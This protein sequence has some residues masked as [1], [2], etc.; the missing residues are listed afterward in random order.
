MITLTF[1]NSPVAISS[2]YCLG[3]WLFAGPWLFTVV[4]LIPVLLSEP[5]GLQASAN[6][7]LMSCFFSFFFATGLHPTHSSFTF[8]HPVPI[9]KTKPICLHSVTWWQVPFLVPLVDML[10]CTWDTKNP[11]YCKC[12]EIY[13]RAVR[14]CQGAKCANVIHSGCFLGKWLWQAL[15]ACG[16]CGSGALHW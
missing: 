9:C 1:I 3:C 2:V 11:C 16:L 13:S 7:S 4:N 12:A 14:E 5:T 10:K 15:L 8:V 6:Q